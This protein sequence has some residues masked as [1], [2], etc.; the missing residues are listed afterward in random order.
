VAKRE[1]SALASVVSV[2]ALGSNKKARIIII[3]IVILVGFKAFWD[4]F[5]RRR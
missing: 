2:P 3:I 5:L 4:F 1:I